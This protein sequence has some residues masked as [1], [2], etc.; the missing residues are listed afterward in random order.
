MIC[1]FGTSYDHER[2]GGQ[3]AVIKEVIKIG[4]LGED[5]ANEF[6]ADTDHEKVGG[7]YLRINQFGVHAQWMLLWPSMRT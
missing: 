3:S 2:T 1:S 5:E 7:M 6:Q 4:L